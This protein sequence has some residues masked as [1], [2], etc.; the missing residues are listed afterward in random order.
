MTKQLIDIHI[1]Y[2]KVTGQKFELNIKMTKKYVSDSN[3]GRKSSP[4]KD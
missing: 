4:T 3:P 2:S 1:I